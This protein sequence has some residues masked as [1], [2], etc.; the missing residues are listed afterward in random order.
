MITV[1]DTISTVID[2]LSNSVRKRFS[3]EE[4]A[5]ETNR[6]LARMPLVLEDGRTAERVDG[7]T[8]RYYQSIGIVTKPQY[9]GRQ[10]VYRFEHL[11]RILVAKRLQSQGYSLA[12]IQSALPRQTNEQLLQALATLEVIVDPVIV[13]Q[14]SQLMGQVNA[15]RLECFSIG[16]GV[17]LIVD[18]RMQRNGSSLAQHLAAEAAQFV[19][20][21]PGI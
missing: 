16:K 18:P 9:E 13:P 6:L 20:D 10:A 2:L 15:Q 14:R 19:N 11:L 1:T 8:I 5:A 21:S 3:L 12:Q 4:L 7:R 17:T